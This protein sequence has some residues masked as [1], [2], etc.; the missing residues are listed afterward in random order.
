[1]AEF[2]AEISDVSHAYGSHQALK[3][4]S[5]AVKEHSFFG[6]LGPNGSGKT[7]L[8]R[9]MSSLLAPDSGHCTIMGHDTVRASNTVRMNLGVVFQQ[10]SLDEALTIQQNLLF[11]G[12]LYGMN[13]ASL[14]DRIAF[15]SN[16]LQIQDRLHSKVSQLSG[17]LKRRA[18]LVRG[19][20]HQPSLLL[21]DEP[22]TGLDPIARHDFWKLLSSIRKEEGITMILATHLLDEAEDC[23]EVVIMDSGTPAVSGNPVALRKTLGDK[24]LWLTSPN[25]TLLAQ[26]IED[27]FGFK[28]SEIDGSICIK[29]EKALESIPALY[30][31]LQ[32][33]IES[34]TVRNPTL[35][36]VFLM[37][38][39]RSFAP[40]PQPTPFLEKD[41]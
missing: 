36:D 6:L 4:V 5:F 12:A 23:D 2:A 40:S 24:V 30:Q 13:K 20:L 17:G 27:E 31:A 10:P 41:H 16:R 32:D 26:R 33:L 37:Y 38:A 18:D 19:L 29:E 22:T 14:K 21:L 11:H 34:Y 25:T 9:I 8:F 3:D 35:E 1:M 28:T 7:T 15:L 39:N